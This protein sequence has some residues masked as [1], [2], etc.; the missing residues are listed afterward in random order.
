MHQVDNH[1]LKR[2]QNTYSSS[3][4]EIIHALLQLSGTT[5]K[6]KQ[7]RKT[8]T[9]KSAHSS[10]VACKRPFRYKDLK[11]QPKWENSSVVECWACD[12]L[13]GCRFTAVVTRG[14][15]SPVWIFCADFYFSI[16]ST[17]MLP[18]QHL[19]D[20]GHSAKNAG[21]VRIFFSCVDFLC[22]LLFQYRF[23]PHVTTAAPKRSWAFCQKCRCSEDFL[24]LCRFSVLTFISVS[25]PPPCYHSST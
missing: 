14:F 16:G 3:S 24:L 25:V 21:V 13:E 19:K 18:Q 20:P 15:S 10:I 12:W 11:T 23:H 17:P 6:W 1:N 7:P 8:V 22:W 9:D 5:P 2:R 4:S